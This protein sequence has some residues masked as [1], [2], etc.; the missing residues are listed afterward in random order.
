[1][2]LAGDVLLAASFVSYIGCF[3]KRFRDQ[4]IN[5]TMLP[6]MKKA[7]I[8]MS[9]SADPLTLLA[10]PAVVAEWNGQVCICSRTD[11]RLLCDATTESFV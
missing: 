2:L 7:A 6:F 11:G 4:L 3:N 5:G 8:P 10:N 1:M 9:A